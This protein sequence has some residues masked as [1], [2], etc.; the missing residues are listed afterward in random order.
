MSAS[1]CFPTL[2]SPTCSHVLR[3]KR[4]GTAKTETGEPDRFEWLNISQD[5]LMGNTA[6]QPLPPL[7]HEHLPLFTSF[8]QH[9]QKVVTTISSTIAT[10]LNLPPNTFT[11]LQDPTK[12][13]G[14]IV[15]LI[16]VFGTAETADDCRT[17]MIHH[18]DFGTITLLANVL[19]GLQ[20]LAPG[21]LPSDTSAWQWVQPRPGCLVVVSIT[22]LLAPFPDPFSLEC[23]RIYHFRTRSR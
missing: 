13:S 10:Q 23:F 4:R 17:S 5:S 20:I 16:K 8:L 6:L 7:V 14:T 15:R 12:A 3:F 22:L 19:G 9:S 1:Q 21:R 18:T 11:S 2:C